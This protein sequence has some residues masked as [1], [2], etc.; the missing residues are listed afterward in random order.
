[1]RHAL[2]VDVVLPLVER[3]ATMPP[4]EEL[5]ETA[6]AHQPSPSQLQ[7]FYRSGVRLRDKMM[8]CAHGMSASSSQVPSRTELRD[9]RWFANACVRVLNERDAR[10]VRDYMQRQ[11]PEDRRL[12]A[13]MV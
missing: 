1:M 8:A 9:W 11:R 10:F 2:D 5:P 13:T 6:R 3:L 4:D 12:I 7:D